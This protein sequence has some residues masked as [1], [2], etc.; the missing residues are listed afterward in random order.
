MTRG[1]E[2]RH[3]F[4]DSTPGCGDVNVLRFYGSGKRLFLF[5]FLNY[6][7]ASRAHYIRVQ[8]APLRLDAI[9]Q[10]KMPIPQLPSAQTRIRLPRID[11][12]YKTCFSSNTRFPLT[13]RSLSFLSPLSPRLYNMEA[14]FLNSNLGYPTQF[15]DVGR[16][17]MIWDRR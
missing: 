14:N 10:A 13:P 15:I 3:H 6:Y 5:D 4:G 1:F 12:R 8:S 17:S 16:R 2:R 9:T 11:E 7:L